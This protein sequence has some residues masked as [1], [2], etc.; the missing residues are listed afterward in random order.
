[1]HNAM[2]ENSGEQLTYRILGIMSGSSLD[3][4]DLAYCIFTTGGK[5]WT[6]RIEKARTIP[7]NDE[8]HHQLKNPHV[9]SAEEMVQLDI[10][11]GR[12]IGKAAMAFIEKHGLEKV[13]FFA[14]HGHTLFHNPSKV[15]TTQIGNG[16]IMAAMSKTPV[17]TD[18]RSL[19]VCLGGQGAPLVPIGDEYLFPEYEFCLNVGGYANISFKESGIRRGYDICPVNKAIGWLVSGMNKTMDKDGKMAAR[20]TIN[21]ALLDQLNQLEYY[22][23]APPKSL[24]DDWLK[25]HFIRVLEDFQAISLYDRL[26]TVYEHIAVQIKKASEERSAGK[27]LVTGGGAYN[28]FLME[29]IRNVNDNRIII[30]ESTLVEFKEALIFALMGLL[31]SKNMINCLA[32]VTGASQDSSGG[33][34]YRQYG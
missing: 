3:G 22:S 6:Y 26:R 9:L 27:M 32:S 29:C 21:K 23:A 2:V 12:F 10:E 19:D 5:R 18:F 13:G 34:I 17:I 8:L 16:A 28:Q 30:P 33:I 1:M 24:G 11:L 7:F 14:S 31:R 15:Y 20:G 4:I 25:K